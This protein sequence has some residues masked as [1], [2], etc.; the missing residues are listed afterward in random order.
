MTTQQNNRQQT[1]A[2]QLREAGLRVTR[3]RLLVL[4]ALRQSGGHRSAEAVGVRLTDGGASLSRGTVYKVL[5]DL[6]RAG[7]V[8]LADRGPG[9]ALY[10]I[11]DV[12]HHHF[13]CRTCG[14]VIDVPCQIGSKPCL[15]GDLAGAD[16]DEAQVIFRGRCPKCVTDGMASQP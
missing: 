14:V 15:E 6:V 16:I 4:E 13:V 12:W 10:E 1:W 3:Q 2:E 8:M 5:D 11:A 7:I 9:T